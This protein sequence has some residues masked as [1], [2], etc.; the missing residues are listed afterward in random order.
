MVRVGV[1][2]NPN[3]HQVGCVT[4]LKRGLC[5][6]IPPTCRNG[7]SLKIRLIFHELS[8]IRENSRFYNLCYRVFSKTY[9]WH[10]RCYM[11]AHDGGFK[12]EAMASHV[13]HM[14]WMIENRL[15]SW[16]PIAAALLFTLLLQPCTAI[17]VDPV[18]K[19]E[20]YIPWR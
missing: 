4:T 13:R 5:V 12:R 9:D 18:L 1:S 2:P 10:S 17:I 15:L 3:H 14:S 7:L 20:R 19:M 16:L 8:L 6:V 11:I